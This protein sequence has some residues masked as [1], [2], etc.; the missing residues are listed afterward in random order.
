MAVCHPSRFDPCLTHLRVSPQSSIFATPP[1]PFTTSR[2]HIRCRNGGIRLPLS[3]R[4]DSSESIVKSASPVSPAQMDG[5]AYRSSLDSLFVVPTIVDESTFHVRYLRS[6]CLHV[7]PCRWSLKGSSPVR[8]ACTHFPGTVS[9]GSASVFGNEEQI[10]DSIQGIGVVLRRRGGSPSSGF[11]AS[12]S[13]GH[14][15]TTLN[16]VAAQ[17][18]RLLNSATS[19][20]I[21]SSL[22]LRPL[23]VL[24]ELDCT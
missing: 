5:T 17:P 14:E 3:P 21:R 20:A 4:I 10:G 8:R 7:A 24:G 15:D 9:H 2:G 23:E 22:R 18:G 16:C 11:W 12:V 6:P 1:A 13:I 19:S